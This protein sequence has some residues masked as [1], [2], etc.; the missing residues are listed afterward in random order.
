MTATAFSGP[1]C[2]CTSA[3][4]F[5]DLTLELIRNKSETDIMTGF[6]VNTCILRARELC[7]C[8]G[9]VGNQVTGEALSEN[10]VK[11]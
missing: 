1:L 2:F 6:T 11:L 3:G 9:D 8:L 10:Q 4:L 7:C 5:P